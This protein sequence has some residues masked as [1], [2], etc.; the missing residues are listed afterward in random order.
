[1][2]SSAQL[3]KSILE[4]KGTVAQNSAVIANSGMALSVAKGVAFKEGIALAK[5][6]LESGKAKESFKRF[7]EIF[8]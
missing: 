5:E 4:N 6:S 2:E 1:V 8:S 3:F 7:L